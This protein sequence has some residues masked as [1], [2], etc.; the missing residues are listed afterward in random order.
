[1]YPFNAGGN[2]TQLRVICIIV[3]MPNGYTNENV[4]VD[5]A[6]FIDCDV[7]HVSLK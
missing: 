4:F 6:C 2:F 3:L 1:M 7:E 5:D